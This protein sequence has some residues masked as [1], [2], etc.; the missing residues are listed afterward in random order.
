MAPLTHELAGLI[1]PHDKFGTHLNVQGKT[2]D[3]ELELKNFEYAGRALAEVWSSLTIDGHPVHAQYVPPGEKLDT[4]EECDAKWYSRHVRESQYLLQ[5]VKCNSHD[6]CSITRSG[7][8]RVLSEGFLPLSIRVTQTTHDLVVTE[9]ETDGSF[10][11]LMTRISLKL[12]PDSRG[13]LQVPYDLFCQSIKSQL[14]GRICKTC[15]LY[16]ASK[17]SLLHH[18]KHVHFQKEDA[19][20]SNNVIKIRIAARRSGE[21]LCV[22][23]DPV[24]GCED[25]EWMEETE[26]EA[27]SNSDSHFIDQEDIV[28]NNMSNWLRGPFENDD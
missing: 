23:K 3:K 22:I 27:D 14:D 8:K 5:I 6:C 24:L 4:S 21:V 12:N 20:A 17:K 19:H 26:V 11:D 10:L 7:L 9:N 2:V 15:G 18:S 13:F 25:T 16:H 1:L 28:I